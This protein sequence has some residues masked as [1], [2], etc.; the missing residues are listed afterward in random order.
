MEVSFDV[1]KNHLIDF[2]IYNIRNSKKIMRAVNIQRFITPFMFLIFA[3]MLGVYQNDMVKWIMI[4]VAIYIGWVI[5]YPKMYMSSV[6]S[7]LRK[8][9]EQTNGKEELIGSCRLILTDDGIVEESN[10]RT[11]T[12][13]WGDL[14]RLVETEEYVFVFNTEVSAYVIPKEKFESGEYE[15]RYIEMLSNKS[16]KE[17]E[18]WI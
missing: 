16:G 8:N 17:L 10:A 14:I 3:L 7:T 5:I 6:K 11:N 2:S 12:T 18:Q 1:M 4:F 9:L 15:R 13:S